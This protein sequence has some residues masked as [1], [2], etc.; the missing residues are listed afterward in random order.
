MPPAA[1]A[2]AAA[3]PA[4][5]DASALQA[6]AIRMNVLLTT[7]T[8]T[9]LSESD[10]IGDFSR[11]SKSVIAE[12]RAVGLDILRA[13]EPHPQGSNAG[14]ADAGWRSFGWDNRGWALVRCAPCGAPVN[15]ELVRLRMHGHAGGASNVRDVLRGD[16]GG[17]GA[18]TRRQDVPTG[19]V[20]P[21]RL[22]GAAAAANRFPEHDL[23][24]GGRVRLHVSAAWLQH[25][26]DKGI[27]ID[28]KR[29]E[30]QLAYLHPRGYGHGDGGCARRASQAI[31]DRN[32]V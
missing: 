21:A 28:S 22:A 9:K 25:C 11:W 6:L 1:I 23:G 17:R 12:V 4:G 15:A 24:G 27:H 29:Q 26:S 5:W 13:P 3:G 14:C 32:V 16:A 19:G 20:V 7:P 18:T 10:T 2:P 31:D 30:R 8:T